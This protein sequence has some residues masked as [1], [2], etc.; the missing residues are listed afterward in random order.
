MAVVMAMTGCNSPDQAPVTEVELSLDPR[1]LALT[2][3]ATEVSVTVT[4]DGE[5]GVY[6]A[7]KEWVNVTPGGGISGTSVV[8]V[9][10]A[11]NT[12]Y[13]ARETE[14][15]FTTKSGKT[16]LPVRQEGVEYEAVSYTHL[17][18]PTMAVV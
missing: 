9:K 7:D 14:L 10:I 8:K 13:E 2:T 18:L 4:A 12:S 17:T 15:V 6:S 5:W 3:A 16:L 1:E 11:E